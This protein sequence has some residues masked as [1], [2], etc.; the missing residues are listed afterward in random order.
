MDLA[1]YLVHLRN[2]NRTGTST[3]IDDPYRPYGAPPPEGEAGSG[4]RFGNQKSFLED[5]DLGSVD[6]PECR[7]TGIIAYI[8]ENGD[9][10]SRTCACM[11]KR[12]AL[13]RIRQSGMSDLLQRYTFGSYRAETPEQ[14]N[15]LKKAREFSEADEGWFYIFGRSGSGKSHICTA[16]CGELINRNRDVYYM[17]WRDESTQLKAVITDPYE[18]GRKTQ[19]LKR[20]EIL[21]IDD[22]LKGGDSDA[23]IRL[24]YEILNFRYN[25]R[26]LR[27]ILSSETDLKMLLRR[28]EALGGRVYERARGF[29]LQAPNK[30]MRFA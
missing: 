21:Y 16:I 9:L 30:N 1:E 25:D 7:N 3:T 8:A 2:R 20:A 29:V 12:V 4:S 26:R 14:E 19:K 27:T 5:F 15:I 23:D 10:K 17:P 22:F 28:D 13:R 18:Y 11:K 24:A 6:C